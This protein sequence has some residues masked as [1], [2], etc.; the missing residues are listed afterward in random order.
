MKYVDWLSSQ[1]PLNNSLGGESERKPRT[2]SPT[3]QETYGEDANVQNSVE[4]STSVQLSGAIINGCLNILRF[5]IFLTFPF[6]Y[7]KGRA[8][9][10]KV[11]VL[12]RRDKLLLLYW[13]LNGNN[14]N[15]ALN[16]IAVAPEELH[17]APIDKGCAGVSSFKH[18]KNS[19]NCIQRRKKQEWALARRLWLFFFYHRQ[20][21]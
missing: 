14:F 1:T 10:K 19:K 3:Q 6:I 16:F 8:W 2:P 7:L 9:E 4:G 12:R 20:Q 5:N 15:G 13:N 21:I 17:T 18:L 11:A